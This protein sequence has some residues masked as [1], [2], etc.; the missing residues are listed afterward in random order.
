MPL[1]MVCKTINNLLFSE[2]CFVAND[3]R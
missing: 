2:L 3:D 1:R